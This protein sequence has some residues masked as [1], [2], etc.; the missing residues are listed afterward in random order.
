MAMNQQVPVGEAA[1]TVTISR[2]H[3]GEG[4]NV[5]QNYLQGHTALLAGGA[6]YKSLLVLDGE[7]EAYIHVTAIK[8]RTRG[9]HPL[10]IH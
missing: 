10:S 9:E 2:S 5:V 1:H 4:G 3:T 6:G 7:A 8:V